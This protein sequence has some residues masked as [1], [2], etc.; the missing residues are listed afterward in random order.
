M[1]TS[2]KVN[3]MK[4]GRMEGFVYSPVNY[5]RRILVLCPFITIPMKLSANKKFIYKM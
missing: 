5:R 4:P 3:G 1:R 2:E